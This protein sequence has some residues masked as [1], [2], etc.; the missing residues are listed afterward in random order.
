MT[1]HIWHSSLTVGQHEALESS[2]K[3]AIRIIVN[4]DDYLT[5][6]IIAG[7]DS[8]QTRREHL[9]EQFFLR[10]VLKE[11]SSL[12]YLLPTKGRFPLPEF[13]ARVHGPS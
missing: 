10:N 4:H 1:S 3:R 7:I 12:H 2:Q 13:R 5:S 6:L 8:L 11:Q 9:T